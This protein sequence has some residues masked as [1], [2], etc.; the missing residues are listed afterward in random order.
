MIQPLGNEDNF[1]TMKFDLCFFTYLSS[2]FSTR[3]V[4]YK[5]RS[6]EYRDRIDYHAIPRGTHSVSPPPPPP[7]PP[8]PS[9]HNREREREREREQRER[10]RDYYEKY[11]KKHKRPSREVIVERIPPKSWRE[12]EPP[13]VEAR[14]RGDEW[15]DPW[16]RRKSPSAV[17]RN[18]SS[19]RPRRQ[20]YSSCSSYSSTRYDIQIC[21]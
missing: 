7:P 20:S 16:M 6:T 9:S 13:P 18:T 1:A 5:D 2:Y 12:E 21:T 10:E 17:R 15:A 3:R 19:R 4:H 11:E 8:P 14:G